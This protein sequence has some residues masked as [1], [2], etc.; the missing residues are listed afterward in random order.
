MNVLSAYRKIF[1]SCHYLSV[2]N[3]SVYIITIF[4]IYFLPM[5]WDFYLRDETQ[6][7]IMLLH[8]WG[9]SVYFLLFLFHTH[10]LC[11]SNVSAFSLI[12][13]FSLVYHRMWSSSNCELCRHARQQTRSWQQ[14][15]IHMYCWQQY[16]T[17]SR[18]FWKR[19]LEW[20]NRLPCW[21]VLKRGMNTRCNPA[22]TKRWNN[23]GL[24]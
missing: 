24:I 6:I 11:K 20:N 19:Y 14:T 12:F 8:V 5:H 17:D 21:W 4:G 9:W 7:I 23:V 13:Q 18:V 3:S 22:G 16:G 1:W 15:E 2:W 10:I